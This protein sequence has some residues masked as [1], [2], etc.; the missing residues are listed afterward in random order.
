MRYVVDE[1]VLPRALARLAPEP[2]AGD[3]AR[4]RA[5]IDE[6]LRQFEA[7]IRAAEQE[8][9]ALRV[10]RN[11]APSG[12]RAAFDCALNDNRC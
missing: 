4:L 7:H 11:L 10:L 6:T 5:G 2:T 12:S 8:L 1:K 3:L 9:E